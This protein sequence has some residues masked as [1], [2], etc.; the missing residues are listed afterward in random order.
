MGRDH[1]RLY[2]LLE[3]HVLRSMEAREHCAKS[4]ME[5][6]K[7]MT[8]AENAGGKWAGN[9]NNPKNM[10]SETIRGHKRKKYPKVIL[11]RTGAGSDIGP[12]V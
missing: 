4:K 8:M 2:L 11:H 9:I 3:P 1:F 10:C 6:R 5:P 7:R 12:D